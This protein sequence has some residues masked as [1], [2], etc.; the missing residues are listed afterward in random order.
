MS[1]W[2]PIIGGLLSADEACSLYGC[3]GAVCKHPLNQP[4]ITQQLIFEAQ[5]GIQEFRKSAW[6]T[7][8]TSTSRYGFPPHSS[9]DDRLS[10]VQKLLDEAERQLHNNIL[11][12]EFA[13]AVYYAEKH[14]NNA[15]NS[16]EFLDMK[17]GLNNLLVE[18]Y[19]LYPTLSP[20]SAAQTQNPH[21]FSG[22]AISLG[23]DSTSEA[24]PSEGE[25]D[26]TKPR[27]AVGQNLIAWLNNIAI[28]CANLGVDFQYTIT[29]VSPHRSEQSPASLSRTDRAS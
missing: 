11:P 23:V 27:E 3:V 10:H 8:K 5:K 22:D 1:W 4:M 7:Y 14:R 9:I 21:F 19:K 24:Q 13:S 2:C 29:N 6:A 15:M 12:L 26:P 25:R 20:E 18:L 16:L 28:Y 17:Q